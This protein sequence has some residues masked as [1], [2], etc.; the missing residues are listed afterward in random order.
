MYTHLTNIINGLKY[1]ENSQPNVDLV[2]KILWSL[3]KSWDPKLIAIQDANNLRTQPLG[4]HLGSLIT[5]QMILGDDQN[6]KKKKQ[7]VIALKATIETKEL[8]DEDMVLLIRKFKRFLNKKPFERRS[9]SNN[10]RR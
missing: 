3:P 1:L 7:K 6:K 5:H 2:Y 9:E 10:K 8:K 4:Q